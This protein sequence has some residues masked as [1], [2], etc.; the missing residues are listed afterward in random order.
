MHL[1]AKLEARLPATD[2]IKAVSNLN[3]KTVLYD[4]TVQE[5]VLNI[6]GHFHNWVS[7]VVLE[8]SKEN[9]KLTFENLENT[10]N[11]TI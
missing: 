11:Q 9:L 7:T 5:F 1:R 10:L 4:Y 2:D 6:N 3:G 8:T